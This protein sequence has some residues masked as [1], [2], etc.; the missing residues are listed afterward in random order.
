METVIETGKGHLGGTFSC[1][2]ILVALYYGGILRFDTKNPRWPER[3]R[4][5]IGKGHACLA[6]YNILVDLGFFE[7]AR[8]KE[9][10]KNGSSL[11]GQLNINTPGVEY[12]TGSLGNALGIGAGIALA[13]K[14]DG[15]KYRA[16]ALLGDGECQEGSIWESVMFASQQKLNNLIC[17]I[18]RNRLSVTDVVEEDDGSGRLED[19]FKT[20]GWKCLVIDGH[21][22]EEIVS[23]FSGLDELEQPLVIIAN[24]VKG[25]GVSFMENGVKWHHAIPTK[26][27]LEIARKELSQDAN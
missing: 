25:K 8:L 3:D 14:M 21:S 18:D 9:Y 1:I 11:G 4:L 7:A 15:K 26:E 27:E 6:V 23:A 5:V 13:A 16:F 20:C 24:T 12:N 19:K 10:G 2:D 22:F 17:I